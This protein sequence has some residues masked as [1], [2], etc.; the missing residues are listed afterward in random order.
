MLEVG[1]ADDLKA[2][3]SESKWSW[4]VSDVPPSRCCNT[5]LLAASGKRSSM[6]ATLSAVVL[7]SASSHNRV[8]LLGANH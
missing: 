4:S 3:P 1:T 7:D 8:S 6:V 5:R 2:C